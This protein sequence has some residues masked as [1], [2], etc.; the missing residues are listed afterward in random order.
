MQV[1]KYQLIRK[2][3][4]G[5]MAEVWLANVDGPMGFKK[6][7]VLKRIL[8]HLAENAAFLQMFFTEARLAA[9]LNHPHIVQIFDFGQADGT[10]YL[11]MEYIEGLNLRA[12]LK[13]VSLLKMAMSP[14]LCARLIAT[15]CE[16]L[17]FAH[18]L[19]ATDTGEPLELIHRD[20][21][22]DNIMVSKQ[23]SLKIV[24]FGIAKAADQSHLT[25]TGVIKGKLSYMAPEQLRNKPLDLRVDV[26]SLG[27]VFYELLTGHKPF[28][29]T[30]EASM[31]QAILFEPPVSAR[32]YRPDLPQEVS[33]IL[34]RALAKDREKRYPDCRAFH[35]DLED[36]IVATGK[37]VGEQRIAHFVSKLME[38]ELPNVPPQELARPVTPPRFSPPP[39]PPPSQAMAPRVGRAI[40]KDHEAAKPRHSR[41][42]APRPDLRMVEANTLPAKKL[43][44]PL[45]CE[46]ATIPVREMFKP[47]QR[48]GLMW[49]LAC[50]GLLVAGGGFLAW[51]RGG[52]PP[53][54][55]HA[56]ASRVEA[57][58]QD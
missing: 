2:L 52:E 19:C 33:A 41:V 35:A 30:S 12:L 4:A 55:G 38:V 57:A 22:L 10:Y 11:A 5:G 42:D 53:T 37:K 3:A 51:R 56:Q 26:Y 58:K 1:G 9:R 24:D 28:D 47:H 31:A 43:S 48:T 20:V 32:R 40:T 45:S 15:A 14:V 36:Y 6:D 7:V 39:P 25:S 13:R 29:A 18:E 16:G 21:S 17:T 49:A 44:K 23:G 46:V 34:D 50:V 8:P 54:V 27:V